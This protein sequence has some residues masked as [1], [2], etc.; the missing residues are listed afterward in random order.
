MTAK[1]WDLV[2]TASIVKIND[3][4]KA[5][6]CNLNK[7]IFIIFDS[8]ILLAWIKMIPEILPLNYIIKWIGQV[9]LLL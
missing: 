7:R 3:E 6:A 9:L 5:A 1:W 2:I 4:L 8:Y